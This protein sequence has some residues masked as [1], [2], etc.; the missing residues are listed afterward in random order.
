MGDLGGNLAWRMRRDLGVIW[1]GACRLGACRLG[2]RVLGGNL[3][4]NGGY[5]GE[6]T[7]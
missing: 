1:L 5:I 4:W 2:G 7:A 3:A 6:Y